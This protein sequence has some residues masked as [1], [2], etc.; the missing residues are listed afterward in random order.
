MLCARRCSEH[1]KHYLTWIPPITLW[2][3]YRFPSVWRTSFQNV[4][5]DLS[6]VV[7]S[8][9]LNFTLFKK[10]FF[11]FY[12]LEAW[13]FLKPMRVYEMSQRA[14]V[15]KKEKTECCGGWG[16]RAGYQSLDTGLMSLPT[17]DGVQWNCKVK[18]QSQ[19]SGVYSERLLAGRCQPF[20]WQ[21]CAVTLLYF[22]HLPYPQIQS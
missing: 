8:S 2:S 9:F 17:R 19:S 4:S 14:E 21:A 20:S 10:N 11:F 1:F 15:G 22:I 18:G 6:F 13:K 12:W 7:C 16:R 5:M 3:V